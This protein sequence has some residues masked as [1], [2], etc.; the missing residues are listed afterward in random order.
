MQAGID[1]L[2]P[3]S[4]LSGSLLVSELDSM[5]RENGL[6]HSIDS[7]RSD[8]GEVF[9]SHTVNL[10]VQRADLASLVAFAEEVQARTPYM[11][12][13]EVSLSADRNRPDRLDARFRISSVELSQ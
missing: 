13:E 5:A 2:D 7:P 9:I 11:G 3:Q 6:S 4:I 10:N 1:N 12:L 8:E